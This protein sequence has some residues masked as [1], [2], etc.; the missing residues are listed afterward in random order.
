MGTPAFAVPSLI[1]LVEAGYTIKAVVTA[2]NRAKGRGQK[3]QKSDVCLAAERLGIP[4]LQPTN[5]KAEDF[6]DQL[7]SLKPDLAVVVAFRMLPEAVWSMPRIGTLNLHGSLL[8]QYRGAAPIH[9][10]VINGERETG[11]TTF[12]LQHAIDTGDLLFQEKEP[13]GPNDTTGDV[14]ERLMHKGAALVV[15]TVKAIE[16]GNYAL[17]PQQATAPLHHAPKLH[18]ETCRIDFNRP[19]EAVHN[20]VR[21]LNPFPSAWTVLQDKN[22]KIHRVRPVADTQY[23]K[24]LATDNK[25]YLHLGCSDGYVAVEELQMEGKKKMPIGEFLRGF[26]FDI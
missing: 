15:K 23:S 17:R 22:F 11:V 12:M 2:P 20:F 13:I 4:V 9:W 6:Q 21:G 5:L 8:P 7:R 24:P 19:A 16:A 26:S 14:Y 10:A 3:V 25:T 1:A 18:K